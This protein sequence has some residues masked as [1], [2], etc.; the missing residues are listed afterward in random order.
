[1]SVK[2]NQTPGSSL[3]IAVV[4]RGLSVRRGGA[5]RFTV[6]FC[7]AL[8]RA[9]HRVVVFTGD[10][11]DPERWP[12]DVEV[13]K[14]PFRSCASFWKVLS[15][16]RGVRRLLE[17][18]HFDLVYGLC[19]FFPL[20]FYYAGGGVHRHWM[21]LRYPSG[22]V[23]F[24]RYLFSPVHLAMVWLESRIFD[25]RSGHRIVTNSRLVRKHVLEYYG[26][27]EERIHV[28]YDGVDR[29]LFHP[30][31]GNEGAALRRAMGFE[32]GDCVALF[33]SNNW[34]RKGLDTILAAMERLPACFRLAVVGRGNRRKYARVLRSRGID[35]GRVYFAGV[36]GDIQD[37][38]AAA[39]LL[40][41]PTRYDPF[42]QVCREALACGLPVI[43]TASNGAAEAIE[44]G[45]NG[46]VLSRWDDAA[47]LEKAWTK[48]G[49][50][51]R[52]ETMAANAARSVAGASWER[53]LEQHLHV[54]QKA[55]ESRN[56][57]TSFPGASK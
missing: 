3:K 39:D 49:D 20:D 41:L 48:L 14:V 16:H 33:A 30:G 53:N 56:K 19:Q 25:P 32:R 28:I 5:E 37:C 51:G 24:A 7:S 12:R 57:H 15:F 54:F 18:E 42:A 45:S 38:Y 44:S 55:L 6:Q 43:T 11:S 21:R 2:E 8:S 22:I 23:R 47:A 35:P 50:R 9:G 31:R 1:M 46:Y 40:I 36:R 10:D 4:T 27:P 34:P 17:N 29:S 52:L 13:R 26:F